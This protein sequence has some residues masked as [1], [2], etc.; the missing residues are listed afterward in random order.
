MTSGQPSA[1][2]EPAPP[3]RG[4]ICEERGRDVSAAQGEAE[5]ETSKVQHYLRAMSP[6][7]VWSMAEGY[8]VVV[9]QFI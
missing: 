9:K 7:F 3:A 8:P 5:A 1:S 6:R 4:L 2:N